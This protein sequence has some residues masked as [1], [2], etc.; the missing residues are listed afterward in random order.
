MKKGTRVASKQAPKML[1]NDGSTA[2]SH[3]KS[4]NAATSLENKS[5]AW[6]IFLDKYKSSEVIGSNRDA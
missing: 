6:T 3:H 4:S 5:C 2:D 1:I